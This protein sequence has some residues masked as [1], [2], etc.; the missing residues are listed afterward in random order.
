[1][2]PGG[3]R[4]SVRVVVDRRPDPRR[5]S[6]GARPSPATSGCA[7]VVLPG[8]ANGHSHAFHRALRGRTHDDGGNFWTWR[9]AMYAVTHRLDPETYHALAK[10]VFAEMVLAGYTAVG[11][12]HY[13]HHAPGGRRYDDPNVM[14]KA[15]ISAAREAGIRITL[16]DT[17]YLA[18]GLTAGGHVPLDEVQQRFSDGTRRGLG[19]A[20]RAACRTT[21]TVRIGAAVHSVRAVPA[22]RP[23]GRRRGRGPRRPAAARAPVGAAGREPRLRGLLRLLADRAARRGGAAHAEARPW[24]TQLTCPTTTSGCSAR[25]APPRASARRPSA[26]SPTASARPV[27]CTT[28]GCP[29]ARVRP[30]RRHRPL[31][32]DARRRDARAA[33]E[34]RAGPVR[35]HRPAR[36][37]RLQRLPRAGLG[38][39]RR[40]RA[41]AR[42]PTSSPC[43]WTARARPAAARPQVLYAATVRRRHRRRGRAASRWCVDGRHR[44]GD[45]GRLLSR[46]DLRRCAGDAEIDSGTTASGAVL[47]TGIGELVTC[48]GPDGRPRRTTWRRRPPTGSASSHDA[49]VVVVDGRIAWVGPAAR[50]PAAD[51]VRRRRRARRGARVRRQPQPPRLRRRPGRRVQRADGR[52]PLRRRRHRRLGGGH[53]GRRATTSCAACCGPGSP[54]CARSARRPSRSRAATG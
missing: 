42:S 1:M 4:R 28:P 16:L 7:G 29:R 33:R 53:P 13:V 21:T 8:L 31:R 49:A 3:V 41:R 47:V 34:P 30:A 10:A 11:E 32:G 40:D 27:G 24:C 2:L 51:R 38:R 14:G 18:G 54:R 37:G 52:R 20:G 36:H 26:T 46:R 12:F 35:A 23:R 45:V 5:A 25:P 48:A 43:G 15:L 6:R 19:G 9:E 22:R 39:R 17:C 44:A 50:A